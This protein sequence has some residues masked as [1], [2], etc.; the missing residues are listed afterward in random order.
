MLVIALGVSFGPSVFASYTAE[1]PRALGRRIEVSHP[2]Q[3]DKAPNGSAFCG[4]GKAYLDKSFLQESGSGS[5]S[6]SSH[7]A[8]SSSSAR[9]R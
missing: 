3:Q 4:L 7:G 8:S 6:R 9:S 2:G 1:N 5:E